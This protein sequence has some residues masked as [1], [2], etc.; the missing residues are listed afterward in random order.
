[1]C[2]WM[3]RIP[4]GTRGEPGKLTA[5]KPGLRAGGYGREISLGEPHTHLGEARLDGHSVGRR[6][7]R[8]CASFAEQRCAYAQ[9]LLSDGRE[10][11]ARWVRLET[12][13]SKLSEYSDLM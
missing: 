5:R 11:A 10:Q 12:A 1:M 7:L 2:G 13:E 6:H 4:G 9:A 3:E 8:I